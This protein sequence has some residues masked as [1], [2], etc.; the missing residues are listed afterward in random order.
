MNEYPALL[1]RG[2]D[3]KSAASLW[4]KRINN[5]RVKLKSRKRESCWVY[6][7]DISF[8]GGLRICKDLSER[9]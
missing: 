7:S 8:N 9:S 1:S 3:T 4:P 6:V 5:G 2:A